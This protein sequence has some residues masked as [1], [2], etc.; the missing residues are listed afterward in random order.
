MAGAKHC[1]R[2][3]HKVQASLVAV[4]VR[5]SLCF[6]VQIRGSMQYKGL[7]KKPTSSSGGLLHEALGLEPLVRIA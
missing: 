5:H 1:K 4:K 2:E 7:G 3:D 6:A